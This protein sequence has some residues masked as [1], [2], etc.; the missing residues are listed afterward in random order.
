MIK[1][2]VRLLGGFDV[3][4]CEKSVQTFESQKVRGLFAYLVCHRQQALSRD[5]LASLLWG[6]R[7][8]DAARRNL[9]QALHNLRSAFSSVGD[10]DEILLTTPKDLQIHPSLDCWID[11]EEFVRAAE[12]G[13]GGESPD[14]HQLSAAARLYTG[15][16]LAGFLVKD[17]LVFEEWLVAEQERLRETAIEVYRTLIGHYL[18]R[19][20]YP[21]G[22]Q[23]ARR[24]LAIDP[25]SEQAHRRIMKLYALSGHR[26]RALAQYDK[27]RNLLQAELA[28][29]PVD[30]STELY[31]SILAQ[32]ITATDE[33]PEDPPVGPLIPLVGRRAAHQQLQGIW[34]QVQTG[35]GRLT[36]VTGE[37]G[38]GKSR[39]IRSF[40]HAAT[41]TR[42]A[43]V[44][45]G[46][47]YEA[48]PKTAYGPF[49][50]LVA[51]ALGDLI[52]YEREALAR[53]LRPEIYSELA[54]LAHRGI[55]EVPLPQ[56]ASDNSMP[57]SPSRCAEVILAL[58]NLLSAPPDDGEALHVVVLLDN[59]QW[60]DEASV[61][62]LRQL[63]PRLSD[64]RIWIL[65][66]LRQE[67]SDAASFDADSLA[68]DRVSLDRL[69]NSEIEQIAVSLVGADRSPPLCD[70][71]SKRS[72]GLP[73][74]VAELINYLWDE[75][76]LTPEGRGRWLIRA[77][78][79]RIQPPSADVRALIKQRIRRLPTSARRLLSIAA[80]I[81]QRFDADLMQ[82]ADREHTE[83][84]EVCLQLLLERWLIRQ[85]PLSWQESGRERDIVLWARG[86]RRGIFEFVHEEIRSAVLEEVN[87]IRRQAMHRAVARALRYSHARDLD[88]I[89]E[90]LAHHD[91]MARD[92]HSALFS[93][94]AAAHK[95][96]VAG[97]SEIARWYCKRSL[98]SVEHLLGEA[99]SHAEREKL[100][101]EELEIKN[102]LENLGAL[103]TA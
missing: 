73:L 51:S 92:W 25:L 80:V 72:G 33:K 2:E 46:Q 16:F 66:A 36:L 99:G 89:C 34:Q 101:A 32:E 21:M 78:L 42:R 86:V 55:G 52:P 70:F 11:T 68:V 48:A 7:P 27:L 20:E 76:L 30:A 96:V 59:L 53:D 85:S 13:I 90:E 94:K 50:E 26:T 29:E 45:Q 62:L 8:E 9:R 69:G 102:L 12:F 65:A 15:D 61:D 67:D 3:R 5:R 41:P 40:V 4:F 38:V 47:A 77:G 100:E 84:V 60:F 56:G 93:L 95:A 28:V 49:A 6:E 19:G 79:E 97:A 83:V 57:S 23:Y 82:F 87:P 22:I 74:A 39:L 54:V 63:L 44:L 75:G 58:L 91:V 71:L 37:T 103:E 81:G 64:G 14:P 24:L 35:G 1:L 88:S 17:S 98:L 43:V 18:E 10:A 31:Q